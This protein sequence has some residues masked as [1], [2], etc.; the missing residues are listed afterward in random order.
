MNVRCPPVRVCIKM[1]GRSVAGVF[2]IRK[3]ISNY[4]PRP[5]AVTVHASPGLLKQIC[6]TT[7]QLTL[8]HIGNVLYRHVLGRKN[9][10]QKKKHVKM[11]I[12]QHNL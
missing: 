4:I 6:K 8:T 2:R 9:E 12:K 10:K 11:K 3:Y 7:F 1:V 5:N